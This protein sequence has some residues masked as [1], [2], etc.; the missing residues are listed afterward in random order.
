[1]EFFLAIV[2]FF[3]IGG[4]LLCVPGIDKAMEGCRNSVVLIG[5]GAIAVLFLFM[6]YAV[7]AYS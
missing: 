5:F 3:G 1:M 4:A 2:L 6:L 7:I